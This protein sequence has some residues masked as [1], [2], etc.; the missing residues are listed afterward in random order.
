MHTCCKR[1][2]APGKTSAPPAMTSFSNRTISAWGSDKGAI[3]LGGATS[4]T[5]LKFCLVVNV[6]VLSEGV[7]ESS[8]V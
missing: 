2:K 4:C 5:D 6:A 3:K 7:V 1:A 8:A